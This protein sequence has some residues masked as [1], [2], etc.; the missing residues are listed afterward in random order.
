MDLDL[1]QGIMVGVIKE[2]DPMG[3]KEH[4]FV[5]TGG[6]CYIEDYCLHQVALYVFQIFNQSRS[7]F[8]C[9]RS[10]FLYTEEFTSY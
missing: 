5:D 6:M 3:N 1:A 9:F 7:F 8:I 4:W 2:T 10:V